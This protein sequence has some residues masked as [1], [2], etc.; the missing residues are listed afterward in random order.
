[1]PDTANRRAPRPDA[2][3]AA[4]DRPQG[5]RQL[6]QLR[7]LADAPVA[8]VA[9]SHA[10]HPPSAGQ[11]VRDAEHPSRDRDRLPR[12]AAPQGR[13]DR[14]ELVLQWR[15]RAWSIRRQ[16]ARRVRGLPAEPL[17]EPQ[18]RSA[19]GRAAS[20]WLSAAVTSS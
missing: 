14:E 3:R 11:L 7:P 6:P 5:V 8:A 2:R 12:A 10:G 18:A 9:R 20:A 13:A 16:L 4:E 15:A 1:Q 17:A 19:R